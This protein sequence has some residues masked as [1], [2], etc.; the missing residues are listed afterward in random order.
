[1]ATTEFKAGPVT[2][3]SIAP[4]VVISLRYLPSAEDA[5]VAALHAAGLSSAPKQGRVLGH[6]P[7][8]LWRSPSEVILL[9]TSRSPADAAMAELTDPALACAVDLLDGVLALELQ[10]PQVDDLLLRLVDSSSLPRSPGSAVRARLAEIA[11]TLVRLKPDQ[12]WLL[13]EPPQA[14]Y[15]KSWLEHAGAALAS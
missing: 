6:N 5:L 10:G 12:M 8:A 11:V 7:W 1:M 4:L 9:A 2:V 14:H 15:L 13:A 3:R